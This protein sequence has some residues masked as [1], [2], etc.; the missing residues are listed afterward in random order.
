MSILF[1][2]PGQ[3][4]Q[5]PQMLQRLEPHPSVSHTLQQASQILGQDISELDNADALRSTIAVQLCLLIA[6]VAAA[7]RLQAEGCEPDLVAGLSIGAYPAAVVAG[8]LDF[9]S[10]LRLVALRGRLMEQAYPQGYG[11]TAILGLDE[12]RLE[13]LLEQCRQ[14]GHAV[15]LANINAETQLVVAG[16]LSGMQA[17]AEAALAHGA[18]KARRL[19]VSVPSHCPLLLKPAE[20]MVEALRQQT[21]TP[22]KIAYISASS[23][24]A[25]WQPQQIGDDLANNMARQVRWHD[26]AVVA[27]ERGARLAVEM[28][29]GSVLTRLVKPVFRA[30]LAL[31]MSETRLDSLLSFCQREQQ[32][33]GLYAG[34]DNGGWVTD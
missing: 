17:A 6:G 21:L 18:H 15:Y 23:A 24:R 34:N 31:S 10:A 28:P 22:P 32:D 26:S 27:Y 25:L 4:A 7:R 14:A 19:A 20:E 29:P 12:A 8:A 11:M 2:F 1:T 13:P 3:G 30:G 33:A 16:S 9:E 5:T